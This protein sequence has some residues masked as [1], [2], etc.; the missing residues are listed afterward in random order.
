M[1]P[2][3]FAWITGTIRAG[4]SSASSESCAP[5]FHE[6]I[7]HNRAQQ[8]ALAME[9]AETKEIAMM[10]DALLFQVDA[11][12]DLMTK[13]YEKPVFLNSAQNQ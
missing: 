6:H 7:E 3:P 8:Q 9:I 10:A 13:R 12:L 4:S 1:P 5:P 2:E 11:L